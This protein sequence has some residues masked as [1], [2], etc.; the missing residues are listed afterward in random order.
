MTLWRRNRGAD[1]AVPDAPLDDD[2]YREY[3]N[4]S[5]VANTY[6]KG[7]SASVVQIESSKLAPWMFL[8][9]LLSGSSLVGVYAAVS[10]VKNK[11]EDYRLMQTRYLLMERRYMDMEAYAML[12]GWKIPS[13]DSFGPTGNLKRMIES[14]K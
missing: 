11:D 6:T 12:N 7:Q 1:S 14:T 10:A 3:V 2:P 5:L 4:K 13:D 9:C 8:C